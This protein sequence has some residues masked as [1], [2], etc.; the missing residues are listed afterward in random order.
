MFVLCSNITITDPIGKHYLSYIPV[1]EVR[2]KKS[3]KTLTN[4]A[5]ITL[6]RNIKVLGDPQD[7]GINDI[8]K[9]GAAVA[10]QLGYD[11]KLSTRF[12]GY[13]S[14]VN[15]QVPLTI[16]CQDAMWTL[17]QNSITKTWKAGTKVSDI[18]SY[19]YPGL[20]VVANLEIGGLKAVKQSSAQILEG[21]R[22][23]GL[24]VYFGTDSFENNTLYVDFAG[25]V[26]SGKEINY[27]FYQNIISNTL[28]YKLASDSRLKVTGISN[29]DTGKKIQI[30][31]GDADGEEHTLNY[32]NMDALSLQKIVNA[33][34]SSLKYEGY[35]GSFK[36]FGLPESEPGDIAVLTDP[37]DPE[38][39]GSYLIEAVDITFGT[40]GY[41]HD[42]ELERKLA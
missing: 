41:R 28:D 11:N 18:V 12:T 24:Q 4:T 14:N 7:I 40:G 34:I 27:V 20:A 1:V 13:I 9:R 30:V 36:T 16:E 8:I 19:V 21:L 3:R 35:K 29:L 22:K 17:K 32:Y 39:D 42:V 31:A 38:H 33:E 25:A 6:P 10:I 2:I 37:L 15:A 5:S 23:F 26:H